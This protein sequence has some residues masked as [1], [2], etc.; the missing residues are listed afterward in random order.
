M[1]FGLPGRPGPQARFS[2]IDQT[3]APAR[4][5]VARIRAAAFPCE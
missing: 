2:P 5:P 3:L 1:R 4:Y